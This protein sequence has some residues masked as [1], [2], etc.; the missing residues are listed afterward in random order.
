VIQI[1][2]DGPAARAVCTIVHRCTGSPKPV[3][4]AA[5]FRLVVA[6]DTPPAPGDADTLET[7]RRAEDAPPPVRER[8]AAPADEGVRPGE[9]LGRYHVLEVIGKGGMGTVYSAFDPALERRVAIKLLHRT[10]RD[11]ND[12]RERL[13]REAKAMAQLAHPNVVTVHEVSVDRGRVFLAMEYVAGR[14]ARSWLTLKTR[15]WR[16]IVGVYRQAAQGLAAA[17]SAGLL[18]RDVKP[19]NVLVGNDDRV[20]LT[21]FGIAVGFAQLASGRSGEHVLAPTDEDTSAMLTLTTGT[22][23]YMSP[24]QL[25]GDPLDARSDQ[26]SLAVALYEALYQRRPYLGRRPSEL[27]AA[28]RGKPVAFPT[29]NDVP[30]WLRRV[31]ARALAISPDDRWPTMTAMLK[32]VDAGLSPLRRSLVRWLGVLVPAAIGTGIVVGA[33]LMPEPATC[34]QAEEIAQ[35]WNAEA[36]TRV[37]AAL[38]AAGPA[39]A[40]D[41][42]RSVVRL[43][44]DYTA[45]WRSGYEDAC[46]QHRSKVE[47][48]SL[49]DRRQ[50]C[51]RARHRAVD[52]LVEIF[53]EADEQTARNAVA[54]VEALPRVADCESERMVDD[55]AWTLPEDPIA[56]SHHEA[57]LD[58]LTRVQTMFR[59]GR[60]HTGIELAH[61]VLATAR[62]LADDALVIRAL[63]ELSSY[64]RQ[65]DDPEAAIVAVEEAWQLGLRTGNTIDATRAAIRLVELIGYD[66]RDEVLA[67]ARVQDAKSLIERVRVHNPELATELQ[68]AALRAQGLVEIRHQRP[69]AVAR[70]AEA[71]AILRSLPGSH[72]L[73]IASYLRSLANAEFPRGLHDSALSHYREALAL[74]I[75][76]LGPDHPDVGK[77]HNN[78][79]LLLKNMDRAEEGAE[80]LEQALRISEG[81]F[82]SRHSTVIMA[83]SNLASVY[84]LLEQSERAIPM[85]QRAFGFPADMTLADRGSVLR[86]VEYA[87]DL[88]AVGRAHDALDTLDAMLRLPAEALDDRARIAGHRGRA[89]ALETLDRHAEA[90]HAWAAAEAISGRPEPRASDSGTSGAPK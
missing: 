2:A 70:L 81:A 8:A 86:V 25:R 28:H 37:S 61:A 80:H 88:A 9:R 32:Q 73:E 1:S 55:L 5:Y 87:A 3:E 45:Q 34:E 36:R 30:P 22:P 48:D 78:I 74:E 14:S 51:L 89:L 65:L 49:F 64:Q 29:D 43:L 76:L 57:V 75:G 18:H 33:K 19:D 7:V 85:W 39:F 20:R 38:T 66:R 11:A 6:A 62:A 42:A 46:Q 50:S 41:T 69:E 68:A 10:A 60:Y 40:E 63:L 58:D 79:G 16:E 27:R 71:L 90:V 12:E 21:D 83:A 31:L 82:G 72:E 56:R 15:T 26:F 17:H 84:H 54:A 44:D 53:G 23:A 35:S 24:E 4:S 77:V 67:L 47:S 13:V 52:A 59:A